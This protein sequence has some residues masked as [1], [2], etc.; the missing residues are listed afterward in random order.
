[1]VIFEKKIFKMLKTRTPVQ[2][3]EFNETNFSKS[4]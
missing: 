3:N 4:F 1:M 2:L